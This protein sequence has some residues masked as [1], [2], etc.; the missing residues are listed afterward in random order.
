M[1]LPISVFHERPYLCRK[2]VGCV[3]FFETLL[4]Q[5]HWSRSPSKE[6]AHKRREWFDVT[7]VC[8]VKFAFGSHRQENAFSLTVSHT[9]TAYKFNVN[10]FNGTLDAQERP[11]RNEC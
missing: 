5:Q 3:Q 4:L 9:C 7:V 6:F 8:Q 11:E 10:Y 2:Q 1:Y